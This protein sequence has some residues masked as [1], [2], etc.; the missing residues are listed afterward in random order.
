[1]ILPIYPNH[2][3]FIPSLPLFSQYVVYSLSPVL[4]DFFVSDNI[5]MCMTDK[6]QY[7][8][9]YLFSCSMLTYIPES[10]RFM[11][12]MEVWIHKNFKKIPPAVYLFY[13]SI[14]TWAAPHWIRYVLPFKL[15]LFLIWK[16]KKSFH[17][18]HNAV[19]QALW[20]TMI[21]QLHTS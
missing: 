3:P 20:D 15:S 18:F 17:P 12:E 9:V 4:S 19:Y 11:R 7:Q 8:Y 13:S 5:N 14:K 10:S 6:R 2:I 21:D 1:M 16:I